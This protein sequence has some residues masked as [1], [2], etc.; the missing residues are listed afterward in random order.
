MHFCM[1]INSAMQLLDGL[2]ALQEIPA[3][4]VDLT[5]TDIHT[6]IHK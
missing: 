6:Y 4:N 2:K 3:V 1:C 5:G